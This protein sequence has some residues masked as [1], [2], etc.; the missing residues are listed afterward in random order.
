M[1]RWTSDTSKR[2]LRTF[3][4]AFF[5]YLVTAIPLVEWSDTSM[6]KATGIGVLLA[7]VAAGV[8][9]VMNLEYVPNGKP[10]DV[11]PEDASEVDNEEEPK[12]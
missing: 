5:A 1:R 10:D 11:E 6:I 3:L 2:A 7:A 4:Q 8:A 12:V 9:A